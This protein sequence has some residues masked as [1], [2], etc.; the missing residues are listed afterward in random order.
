MT[1]APTARAIWMAAVP[2]PEAPA[3]TSAT[4]PDVRPPCTTSRVERRDE[5]LGHGARHLEGQRLGHAQRLAL[6]EH[7]PL[8]VCRARD[9]AHH[10]V[11]HGPVDHVLPHRGHHSGQLEAGDVEGGG[12]PGVEPAALEEVGPVEGGRHDVDQHL[13]GPGDRVGHLAD[14][15]DLGPAG[16]LDDDERAS[17]HGSGDVATGGPGAGVCHDPRMDFHLSDDLLALTAEATAVGAAAAAALAVRED[18]WMVGHVPEFSRELAARGWLGLT[19]PVES[20]GHGRPPIERVLVYEALIG[21]G[22]PVASTWFADRQIGP[23]LLQY[24]T[25]EQQHRWLP[26]ILDG[27]DTWSIGMSEP[28]AGSDVASLRT[29]AVRDGDHWVVDGAKVW[30][31]GAALA[32]WCYLVART[33]PDAPK[34]KGL[35]EIVVDLHSPGIT[36]RPIVDAT[37]D[38]HFCEVVFD[39]VHVPVD[40]LVGAE[41]GSFSQLMRQMEHER[42]GIDRLVSNRRLYLDCLEVADTTDPLVRQEVAALEA[43]YRIGRL[44]VMQAALEQGGPQMSAIT[45]TFGTEFEQ[46]VAA[47]CARTLGPARAARRAGPLAAGVAQHRVRR[48]LHDHGRHH[49]GAAQ[50]PRRTGPRPPPLRVARRLGQ[51]LGG[52][53]GVGVASRRVSWAAAGRWLLARSAARMNTRR[54]ATPTPRRGCSAVPLAGAGRGPDG[55]PPNAGAPTGPRLTRPHRLRASLQSQVENRRPPGDDSGSLATIPLSLHA[56]GLAAGPATAPPTIRKCESRTTYVSACAS[57]TSRKA[58]G[59]DA[60]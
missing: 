29:R 7:D 28:D 31:S 51:P 53:G 5:G 34:H 46:R 54:V 26:G 13:V 10:R 41:N 60:R 19:W 57:F 55:A 35:S 4:R 18:S 45:K 48:R 56:V 37:G 24:G 36:I 43:G 39:G 52:G 20:G 23:T 44:L 50:H 25:P 59:W 38:R 47:F 8:G 58:T 17:P 27:S 3:C 6:V 40:H 16:R 14:H 1:S 11:A 15:E 30:T 12:R 49:P 9:D 2:T 33:D 32:D 21:E 42:G 22:A